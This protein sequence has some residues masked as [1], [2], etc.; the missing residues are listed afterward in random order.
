MSRKRAANQAVLVNWDGRP[1]QRETAPT[2]F[3]TDWD[4]GY[5][6]GTDEAGYGPNLG[7]LVV[8]ATLWYVPEVDSIG[9]LAKIDLFKRFSRYVTSTPPQKGQIPKKVWIAD[10]KLLYK[11]GGGVQHLERGVLGCLQSIDTTSAPAKWSQLWPYLA[12]QSAS[13]VR[14]LPWYKSFDEPLPIAAETNTVRKASEQLS[15]AFATNNLRLMSMRSAVVFPNTFNELLDVHGNKS[16]VLS[17]TTLGLVTQLIAGLPIREPVFVN[18]DKHGGRN[19]YSSLI[20]AEFPDTLVEVHE[21]SRPISIYRFGQDHQRI[22]MRFQAKGEGFLPAALS[23]MTSKYLRELAMRAF[24]R[25]WC[26][27][28]DDLKPTAGYP[29]DAR[30]F[31]TQIKPTQ[32]QLAISDVALWR[33]K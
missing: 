15:A 25:F 17:K 5:L 26:R 21:E 6:I 22:E 28:V 20:Q 1:L 27:R 4:M 18:C 7:P 24:N 9:E 10:S 11:P 32:K 8:T 2:D 3:Q 14:D 19:K 29:V 12:P 16:E 30:R 31:H 23:S 13:N 33:R